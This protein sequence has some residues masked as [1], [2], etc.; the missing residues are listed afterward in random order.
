MRYQRFIITL[1]LLSLPVMAASTEVSD[2][3][4]FD[5]SDD[6]QARIARVNGGDLVFLAEPPLD[7]VHHHHSRITL[8]AESLDNGWV[9][10]VQ[11]HSHLDAVARTQVVYHQTRA[12]DLTILSYDNIERAWVEGHTVQ[13]AEVGRAAS[14]CIRARTRMLEFNEDGSFS[15]RGGPFMRR[16]LDGYYPMHVSMD[17]EVPRGYLRFTDSRPQRQAGF[18]VQETS[19]GLYVDTWFEG[20]LYTE[21][22][23]EADFCDQPGSSSC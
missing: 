15:L 20:K 5:E 4:W 18:S 16:F 22:R 1:L 2:D 10:M 12:R 8:D 13:L 14:I 21:L 11:C 17:I 3:E 7:P 6:L 9:T 19:A 23:F